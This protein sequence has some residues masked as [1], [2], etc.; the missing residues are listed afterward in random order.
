MI[1]AII[2]GTLKTT[3]EKP[4][5]SASLTIK[6]NDKKV[7]TSKTNKNGIF[8]FKYNAKTIGKNNITI[9]FTQNKCY[10]KTT[11]KTT[12]KVTAKRTKITINSIPKTKLGKTIKIRGKFTDTSGRVLKM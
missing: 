12:F 9:S 3:N 10:K 4:I 2:K 8:T 11:A 5:Q 7:G 6:I 1:N